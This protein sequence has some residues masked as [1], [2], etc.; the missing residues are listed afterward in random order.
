MTQIYWSTGVRTFLRCLCK[1]RYVIA[2]IG[3]A[4]RKINLEQPVPML[5]VAL[6]AMLRML[7]MSVNTT[8]S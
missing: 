3:T 4:M 2:C 1:V 5:F 8:L 7:F 6:S